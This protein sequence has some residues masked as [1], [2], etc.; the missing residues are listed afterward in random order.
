MLGWIKTL[1]IEFVGP[2]LANSTIGYAIY[3]ST[4]SYW[5]GLIASTIIF[6]INWILNDWQTPMVEKF[7]GY[8]KHC[9]RHRGCQRSRA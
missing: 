4:G 6:I 3:L 9:A 2:I 7:F 1:S 8:K 5:L